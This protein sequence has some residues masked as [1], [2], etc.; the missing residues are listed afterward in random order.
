MSV[1][2]PMLV[3]PV[4]E[5]AQL[6]SRLGA[7]D[8]RGRRAQM[9]ALAWQCPLDELVMAARWHELGQSRR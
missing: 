1:G 9:N 6:D 8:R 5:L 7:G 4:L 3:D 2:L